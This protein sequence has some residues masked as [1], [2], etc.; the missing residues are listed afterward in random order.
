MRGSGEVAPD[1]RE[2]EIAP[3]EREREI[4]PDERERE[5]APDEREREIA[6][7]EREWE[8]A[9]PPPIPLPRKPSSR[10]AWLRGGG[11]E[12]RGERGGSGGREFRRGGCE[13]DTDSGGLSWRGARDARAGRDPRDVREGLSNHSVHVRRGR[14]AWSSC[15]APGGARRQTQETRGD[16]AGPGSRGAKGFF[17]SSRTRDGHRPSRDRAPAAGVGTGPEW[18][19][20]CTGVDQREKDI[21]ETAPAPRRAQ[22]RRGRGGVVHT[23]VTAQAE[24]G[25]DQGTEAAP[26]STPLRSQ[27]NGHPANRSSQ[28]TVSASIKISSWRFF[29]GAAHVE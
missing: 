19:L 22:G 18:D 25:R 2:R 14:W 29:A 28:H 10:R 13:H 5:I 11:G 16:D 12:R 17:P 1:E 9:L 20:S 4:A 6:P 21:S 24:T 8:A 23:P 3:D 26:G 7:D 15:R 27:G